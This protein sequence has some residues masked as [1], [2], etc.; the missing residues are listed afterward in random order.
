MLSA[1]YPGRRS[2]SRRSRS[3][4]NSPSRWARSV[5]RS[6]LKIERLEERTTLHAGDL[7]IAFGDGGISIANFESSYDQPNTM[8]FQ[9]DGKV[10]LLGRTELGSNSSTDLALARFLPDGSLDTT[11]G[12][13]HNQFGVSGGYASH[14]DTTGSGGYPTLNPSQG[15][16]AAAVLPNGKIVVASDF[17]SG[18]QAIEVLQLN[19]DGTADGS[20]GY[21]GL[22]T[23]SLPMTD[24]LVDSMVAQPD[25]KI[26]L[27]GRDHSQT[28]GLV[29]VRLT[30]SG[31]LDSSYDF[32]GVA[33]SDVGGIVSADRILLDNSGRILVA[34]YAYGTESNSLLARLT[35]TG[36]LDNTF[37]GTGF[38]VDTYGQDSSRLT[39][40]TLRANG[41]IVVSGA[42]YSVAEGKSL[43]AAQYVP[44][45]TLDP[46]FGN[47][48]TMRVSINAYYQGP[49]GVESGVLDTISE[50][51]SGE[52]LLT[53]GNLFA[54]LTPWGTLDTSYGS[55]SNGLKVLDYALFKTSAV[56][57]S[58][59]SLMLY[60]S[61]N[62]TGNQ[63]HSPK[64]ASQHLLANGQLDFAYGTHV[65]PAFT[66]SGF[67]AVTQAVSPNG[68]I[69]VG[70]TVTNANSG[71]Y[72]IARF[73]TDG[74]FDTTLASN[75]WSNF[76]F[77]IE[78][79]VGRDIL[80]G[81][82]VQ[83]NGKT[84]FG[85][86][87]N[88]GLS[89]VRFNTSSD[90]SADGSFSVSIANW[91]PTAITSQPDSKIL[92]LAVG[93]PGAAVI[94][95]LA[96]GALDTSF[97][98]GG[99]AQIG[100][101]GSP[102]NQWL[103]GL[104]VQPD[105]KIVAAINRGSNL[106]SLV[107]LSATGTLDT[108]FGSNGE[109]TIN[110]GGIVQG[111]SRTPESKLI[112]GAADRVYQFLPNGQ[113]DSNFASGG[114]FQQSAFVQ[115]VACD[116]DGKILVSDQTLNGSQVIRR[117]LS[118]GS[119]D[120]HFGLGGTVTIPS[121]NG[122]AASAI[123]VVN[124]RIYVSGTN[125]SDS[126]QYSAQ[127]ASLQQYDDAST[128]DLTASNSAPQATI[129]IS[130]NV[131]V[132]DAYG[133]PVGSYTGQVTFSSSDPL[134]TLPNN[135]TFSLSDHGARTFS[136]IVLR[137]PG[138]QTLTV[139]DVVSG[140][141][142]GTATVSVVGLYFSATSVTDSNV[143]DL[144][145]SEVQVLTETNEIASGY[146]GTVRFTSDD[147]QASLPSDYTFT[148]SDAGQ[149]TFS[150]IVLRTP[151]AHAVT[152]TDTLTGNLVTSF[153][154][155][156]HSIGLVINASSTM[157]TGSSQS[158]AILVQNDISEAVTNYT[159][160]VH[161]A[162][163]DPLATLPADYA[164][165]T[166]DLGQHSFGSALTLR[167]IGT[168]TI[169]ATDT[170][171]HSILGSISIDV[172]AN[173]VYWDGDGNDLL[174]DNP[175]NWSTDVLPGLNDS[176]IIDYGANDFTVAIASTTVSI[177]SLASR[178]ALAINGSQLLV[179]TNSTL[180]GNL[181]L[182]NSSLG[183]TGNFLVLGDSRLLNS[184]LKGADGSLLENRG[185]LTMLGNNYLTGRSLLNA[186]DSAML[187][188]KDDYAHQQLSTSGNVTITNQGTVKFLGIDGYHAAIYP[189]AEQPYPHFINAGTIEKLGDVATPVYIAAQFDQLPGASIDIQFGDLHLGNSPTVG[190]HISGTVS[191][192][193]GS[194]LFV[195]G[196]ALEFA[197]DSTVN[198]DLAEFNGT[199]AQVQG[200]WTTRSTTSS[201]SSTV[202]FLSTAPTVTDLNLFNS[203]FN[204]SPTTT[205]EVLTLGSLELSN[206]LL[207]GTDDFL[208]LGDSRLL[209]SELKGA[210]GS[211]LENR[212]VLTMLGNNYLTGRSLLNAIDSAMLWSKDDYAHQQLSTSGNVT[213]TNQGTVK[214]LGIDGYHAAIYPA[215][216]QPYPHF[217]NAGTIEKL[218][219]VA[220]PVYIAAQFD[221]LP[222][223]SIDIQFGDLHLGNSP[224]L[225]SHI[226]GTVSGFDGSKLFVEGGALEFAGD[227]TVNVDLAEF[228]GT[229]AQVQGLWTTR[230]TTSSNSSTVE[231]LSTAPT[232]TDLNLFNST[233]NFS[234]TTTPEVLTLGSLELSNSLLQ[235]TDD[236]LVLGDSRLLNSE[237]KG[238]DGSLLENRGVLTMLGNNYLTGRSLLNAIDSAML[239]SKDDY[240]HQQ[241]ST[242]GNVTITNQGTVKFLGIDGY[243]AAIYPAAEQPYPHFINAGTIE[244]LGDVATPVYIAAQFD[245]LPGA[246]IDIQF[247]DLHLGNSPT[248]SSHISGTVS[249]FDGS[250]LF[251]EGGA[252][253]FAGDS[254]VNV[255]LAEFN[256]TTAQVQ[257]LWTTR[258][259]TSSN[260]ST[261]EFLST[262]PT[263]TDLNLFNSTFN[264]SPTT[265]PEVL[266]LGS[267][268]LSNSLLQ[269]TDDFL[270]LGDSRLLNSE[271]KGADGSLLENRGVL[272]MLGN[273]YL[274]GRSLLNAIDSTMLWSKDDYAHQQLSTS[275]NVTITN[276]GTVKFLGID[277]YHA[278]IYPAAEQPYPHFI[279][280]GTIEKLGDVVTP[281]Y[282]AAQFDQLPGASIDIQFGDLH[283]G[284]SPTLSSHISGTVSGFDGSKL[285]VEGGALEFAGDSTVNVDL[286]EFNGTTAQV[287]G[288]WTTRSTTSSNSSTVEF[289]STAPTVTDLNLF[290]ST[291]NFSPT[292]TPEVL[293][294]GSLEL[295]NSLL[296]GTD[297]FLVLGDSR[298]LNSELKGADGSL[299]ENRGVL[300]MLGNNYLTG[301]SLLNAI[302]S[303]MLWSKDDYAHQQLST[304]GNVTITNQGTVKFLGIDGY[305]AAIY[306]AAEQPYPHFINAGTIEKLGDVV[307]PV[308]I[309][310]QFDQLPGASIDIQFGDL[311]LS[312]SPTLSSHI[313][314]TVSGFDG[315]KLFVEGGALEFA[316]DSTVNVDLAEFNGTTAQVQG[317]WT[318][319][320]STSSNSSTVEFLSTAPTITHLSLSSSSFS[321]SP[322]A[323]PEVLT[324]DSLELSNSLLQGTDDFLV[325]GDSRILNS[326]L[327]GA[328]GSLFEN[329]G[330][331]TMLGN[332]YLTGRS[333][334]NAVDSTMLWSKD[335]Y[336]HQLLITS[337]NVTITNEGTAK[338]LGIEGYYAY[339]YPAAEEPY[340]HFINAG[341]IEKL[342]DVDTP[343]FITAQFDQLP[344]ASI[345]I[346]L[347]NLHLRNS[348]TATSHVSGTVSGLDGSKLLVEGGALEFAGD[349]T[350][351]VDLA[352]FNNTTAQ[353]QGLW[354]TRSSTSSNSSTV[355]F[356]STAPTITHLSLSS[357]S[358]S[359]SPTATPEVLTLDS[360]ELS[361]SLLQGTDDFLVLGDSRILNSELK[362]ADGSLFENRGV[363]TMLGN[364]YL[365]GRS[366][367]NA[368]DSTMLW[369][370][371]DYAHQLLIT[372]GNVT[373][374]NEGTAK[375]LGIEGYYAYIYPAAE[376]PY[377]HFIN[378]GTIE[379]L[380]D[381]DT[382]VFITAQFDQLP[383]ASIDIQL[384]NLHL[385]NSPT[386]TSHV[387]GTVSGLDGSKLLVEGGALE[388]AG[389]STVNVDLAEFNNTTAQVQGLWTTRSSTSS[390]SSTVEFLST[391]PTI[392]HLSLSSSSFSFSPT[393]TPEVLTLDSL[394]LSNSLLQGTDDF[395]VLGDSR[396][397]N[398]ELKGADGSLFENRGVLT[399]LGNNYLTGRSLLNAVDSTMLWSKDDYAHQ[400]LITSGNVTI[401]NEGT[402]K[403]LGIEG[404][405]ATIYPAAE[406]P[407]PHFINAGTIE[408][409]GDVDTPVFITAQFDQLPGASIDIQLGNL[410][411]RN[412]PTATSHVSGTVSGLD[413][414][415]LLVEGGALEFAGDSTVNVDLAEF[416]NT[417]VQVQGLWTTRSSTSSN[418]STV[419]FISLVAD[420][421]DLTL[422]NSSFDFGGGAG[423]SYYL[424]NLTLPNSSI[425]GTGLIIVA[426]Q[427]T[428][429]GGTVGAAGVATRLWSQSNM[430]I[431]NGIIQSA[432]ITNWGTAHWDSGTLQFY[433]ASG[434]FVNA[435]GAT[436]TTT[437]DGTFGSVDGN[438]LEFINEGLFIKTGS[439][440]TTYLQMQ[441]F[442]K[443][444]VDI[445]DG[446]LFLGCGYVTNRIEPPCLNCELPGPPDYR[447]PLPPGDPI[448]DPVVIPGN[449]Q[450]TEIG[451]LALLISRFT[452]PGEFGVPG[453]DYGQL[454]VT[455][456]VTLAGTLDVS[457]LNSFVPT[458]NDKYLIIDNLG[459]NPVTGNFAGL[460]SGQSFDVG[461]YQFRI[462]YTGGDGNDV[463][464]T[465]VQS[466]S[467][468][469]P[470]AGSS[471]SIRE[472]ETLWLDAS[473]S[474]DADNDALTY[475]WD[476]NGDDDFSDAVGNIPSLAWSDLI[477]L[478]IVDGQSQFSVRVRASD[479]VN[480]PVDS[481]STLLVVEN[482]APNIEISS[483]SDSFDG[484]SGQLR[485][486]A[487]TAT[488]PSPTDQAS[489]FTYSV[490]WGDG[491]IAD[492]FQSSGDR[493]ASH[494]FDSSGNYIVNVTVL[495]K[496]GASSSVSRAVSIHSSELQGSVLAVGGTGLDDQFSISRNTNGTTR[497]KRG[498]QLVGDIPMPANG[499]TLYGGMGSDRL[500]VNGTADVD[501]FEIYSSR[502]LWDGTAIVGDSIEFRLLN[503]AGGNDV[504]TY[505]SGNASIDGGGG[506]D[507]LLGPNE[508]TVWSITGSNL[509]SIAGVQFA[510]TESLVGGLGNDQFVF[511]A[512]GALASLVDGGGG[513]DELNYSA[514]PSALTI[515]LAN[516]A[517]SG[518]GGIQNIER[519]VGTTLS[520]SSIIGPN[521]TNQWEV[522][523]GDT[524]TL[525]GSIN[526]TAFNKLLGGTE[527]DRF[528][529]DPM[530]SISGLVNGRGGADTVSYELWANSV[531][532]NLAS[533]TATALSAFTSI[534]TFIG[535]QGQWDQ[536]RGRDVNTSWTIDGP[537]TGLA[538]N[539][540]FEA[541]ESLV[542]GDL[543]DNFKLT[544]SES[545]MTNIDGGL[546]VDSI[547]AQ[548]EQNLWLLVA[549]QS[550]SLNSSTQF[551]GME[552]L[553]GGSLDD[554]FVFA[555]GDG[556]QT[557]KGGGSLT[558]D[559]IDYSLS[560]SP[561]IVDLTI[562]SASFASSIVGFE[563]FVGSSS[564]SDR[565]TGRQT[566][567]TW[568][569]DSQGVGTL[570]A[571]VFFG[572]ED[573]RGG[574]GNDSFV[575]SGPAPGEIS[576]AGGDGNDT[577]TGPSS[578]SIWVLQSPG[579]G[580]VGG[581]SFEGV[582]NLRGGIGQD[583]FQI[584]ESGQIVGTLSGGA[585]SNTLDYSTWTVSVAV[586]L[587]MR[588][589]TAI[590]GSVSNFSILIGGSGA[591]ELTASSAA[592]VLIGGGGNDHLVG[593]GG[594]NILVG[595]LGSDRL[596]GRG[597]DDLVIGGRT[598]LDNNTGSL[599]QLLAE[600]SSTRTYDQ[601]IANLN[602]TGVGPRSNGESFL[603]N[604]LE[605][606]IFGDE[607]MLDELLGGTGRDWFIADLE[608][609]LLDR[610]TTGINAERLDA[611]V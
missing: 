340:P 541:I 472:G 284:N 513:I 129:P 492:I 204:F 525:N 74:S 414:S 514:R 553:N 389:D 521:S 231:F 216:E 42:T 192:F 474:T 82:V 87:S 528:I 78:Y 272:T 206:S 586:N 458:V 58:D 406:E 73:N 306:P 449:Y 421:G 361:N 563:R 422:F 235:G 242:S 433:G 197:G 65:Y 136:G 127:I 182:S 270:V 346:Q 547:F 527:V 390:N 393:A 86:W 118:D 203:T 333:L 172:Q 243:H 142:V 189:A 347:G 4:R 423:A 300:T 30:A 485:T 370:K 344:G 441:L 545:S 576:F 7:D 27:A 2:R 448:S 268:E 76:R 131:A 312:N 23:I 262:A 285:F 523:G 310:A 173:T 473:Q 279:N 339:I 567:Q 322:T 260:S 141:I 536:M 247:G 385:R 465:L 176:V 96:N 33:V 308:Y 403:F 11:F 43:L 66:Q 500:T 299:L 566:S 193:D 546:G 579:G 411:L 388:F 338:F 324:L 353:V 218:G 223:A 70:G 327:K 188:S 3:L 419:E 551:I 592:S 191:G 50:L 533:L 357:S 468:P 426:G 336:A 271:L 157:Q 435:A 316:G 323:T 364:N 463:V 437:F 195:E 83:P 400:L 604:D 401:T 185:V 477:A 379:K 152:V 315:S 571:T 34:G 1:P 155:Q 515:N 331:L 257:G 532:I 368:V 156:V 250:K 52:L 75:S 383:G 126:G 112:L 405:Y 321:F 416:N 475:Q 509:G 396:I 512:I 14:F 482:A 598:A 606:T 454:I 577:I 578:D 502:V 171:S 559:T 13:Y 335:D 345:D 317:L 605:D 281:V 386:A 544:T 392:T 337:G 343:V 283:L 470:S 214:F 125:K 356:L 397:L 602:G 137:T 301:R 462:T 146:R 234:P 562:G 64:F 210:D 600:W 503:G 26:V 526:A 296:Q 297:D 290:N 519:F 424:D 57:H 139:T 138:V 522:T 432:Q 580:T 303:T 442:N 120:P 232:V 516:S 307:T 251:V 570:G 349:S 107:Q 181:A 595:G 274:T 591:D 49:S 28:Q 175:L 417:T 19:P 487:L 452:P 105:G 466:N 236:F 170:V 348:P 293:T 352:E 395:L 286:A 569:V 239:W 302:D 17:V 292:T 245:Q 461:G 608:D 90:G 369:S 410:H 497:I 599:W 178:A 93:S 95:F 415:K 407:Y 99:F 483:A 123:S 498:N 165:S 325:L 329:R 496:D 481:V 121:G 134:A 350:V 135:S 564:T 276:Q 479:G 267:L 408:K 106:I 68:K 241:L 62:Y 22:A 342:G 530:G 372:S 609:Q 199:T 60:G 227:S 291:F 558:S 280:A 501:L 149:H 222:G 581:L 32:D 36:T 91:I 145:A 493:L 259:T 8:L 387:S 12:D 295:S 467:P 459:S 61:S 122:G 413:G 304:S 38:V 439:I 377:P 535:G 427:F 41:N 376:E 79:N 81:V 39:A 320:S 98:I 456:N 164:F 565:F 560:P 5:L 404:Y 365:T 380:G 252:L 246:S 447:D 162:S 446:R 190:S 31:Q 314:G 59:G 187:W 110:Y 273:N 499:I 154:V 506:T 101:N 211:L 520:D 537:N 603:R 166:S 582:E 163:T 255:D 45:G 549:Y 15:H 443:G 168:Q 460:L 212:G 186:I 77:P 198:V 24:F 358:F 341:T 334:L 382:P 18:N 588:V 240:A 440:G 10:I 132:K 56:A 167:T 575:L 215:A 294:L 258:S 436:F 371:D 363:L 217:I 328:D 158:I 486:Y 504:F 72:G 332:N 226:S 409:L 610:V 469:V 495:D 574:S 597:G 311:H 554:T 594:R 552:N 491:S 228:N 282:I 318:T 213:I 398:S 263:V 354:T 225:S 589:G 48:G 450:Q 169:T 542:G 54:K 438:C 71:D 55:S 555:G 464:L 230:S 21:Y 478:G 309:A 529:I 51:A 159:G 507:T 611:A 161:F 130:L 391:A 180:E 202:E 484:V 85:G 471:Y 117:Y 362:G 269:G 88:S 119:I 229:T 46:N 94:R 89:L 25:G 150:G 102:S 84:V 476:I 374:T 305:H 114:Y 104:V 248:L 556:F 244:K 489:G 593:G 249:G 133:Q 505:D 179:S 510:H 384:G 453:N 147:P 412:S 233:F 402:A 184:E 457:L 319:R 373:I 128:F 16:T 253:E 63:Y 420:L 265:T 143:T 277:G 490:N 375:F 601:R 261:V 561:I 224:T 148:S 115:T 37:A 538:G 289:L 326:E 113:L 425:F 494:T 508:S 430:T 97:G 111:F 80:V 360:L 160:T 207:Q 264:F 378:A 543:I 209:N 196:G 480:P 607:G 351:N 524:V 140:T 531:S 596:E 103:D 237:L 539:L 367:L 568:N 366:L 573:L 451:S 205:P 445:Q 9:P 47:A 434:G 174:W 92:A 194:K 550:G 418:S 298:L 511:G 40:L 254:T 517:A 238:A 590:G 144:L 177:N 585:G 330:V 6:Q 534:E 455:G 100:L 67:Q 444:I 583:W 44:D 201:N 429:N 278:A 151:G 219:D 287:Q 221:Q 69:V 313:S 29:T 381:V 399:M 587:A 20:Y 355:E 557:I 208:V 53:S 124:G 288:L 431:S 518:T 183:G 116:A 153:A 548:A 540:R 200:L 35:P 584:T 359:F 108:S 220:T 275:G 572:F 109:T 266:T 428:F 488:D 256:G 394:E